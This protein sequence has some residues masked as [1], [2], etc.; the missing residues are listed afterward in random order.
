MLGFGRSM[1]LVSTGI[2]ATGRRVALFSGARAGAAGWSLGARLGIDGGGPPKLG[3]A[4]DR[5]IHSR[6][7]CRFPEFECC[8]SANRLSWFQQRWPHR[9]RR[10]NRVSAP[11]TAAPVA[12][13]P[14]VPRKNPRA[15]ATLH[16]ELEVA[17][18]EVTAL[19]VVSQNFYDFPGLVNER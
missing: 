13:D 9:Q 1:C 11:D 15:G 6:N 14:C 18:Q 12:P 4:A 7:F 16:G 17:L 10:P 19:R 3:F 5:N 8:T 2:S